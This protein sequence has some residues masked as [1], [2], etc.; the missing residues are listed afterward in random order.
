MKNNPKISVII[1]VYNVEKYISDSIKSV[2]N[3]TY[4]N[5]EIILVDDGSTDGSSAICDKIADTDSRVKVIHKQN[6][7]VSSARNAGIDACTGEYVTFMDPD[8][9]IDL[10]MYEI[11][12]NQIIDHDADASACG[13]VREQL[14]GTREVWGSDKADLIV[15]DNDKLLKMVGE[16]IGMLPVSCCNKM[17]SRKVISDIRFDKTFKFAEDV[18]FNYMVAEN[19]SKMVIQDLPRYHY[20]DNSASVTNR[21][22]DSVRFDEHKVMDIILKRSENNPGVYAYCVKGDV[23]KAFRTIKDMMA[24]GN[25]TDKFNEIRERIVSNKK[26]IL[27]SGIYSKATKLKTL[28]ILLFP[29]IYKKFIAAYAKR[30]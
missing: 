22:F 16:A 24:A 4:N 13:I 10:D 30:R 11:M 9:Y 19:I 27:F 21:A 28:F 29:D 8:D 12:L 3:Q 14:D 25:E 17:F 6:G 5:L 26:A 15:L 20:I 18:L 7:G 23:L 2:L 1:P